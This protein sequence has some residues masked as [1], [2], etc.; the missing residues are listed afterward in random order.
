MKFNKNIEVGSGSV[1]WIYVKA[2][3]SACIFAL[4]IFIIMALL[5]TYTNIS[6][7]I[8]PMVALIVMII[9]SLI[10]G[11]VTG[12]KMKKKGLVNGALVGL[13]YM[14]LIIFMSWVLIQDFTIG[15]TVL[16]KSI[17]GIVAGGV[18]GMIG[19][20]LK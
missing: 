6:E 15:K 7:S 17:I 4:L 9:S 11:M 14:I 19:V 12:S 10:S 13:C 20:N 1:V 2:I 8:I 5:I 16:I 3:L 18:G